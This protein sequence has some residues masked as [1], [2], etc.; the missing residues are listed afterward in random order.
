MASNFN[1]R[2]APTPAHA[3]VPAPDDPRDSTM[4][5]K[6]QMLYLWLSAIFVT[7]LLIAN[8]VGSKFFHFGTLRIGTF[9]LHIEHS[10][11]MLS[12]PLTFVLTDILNEFFGPKAARRVTYIGLAMSLFAFGLLGISVHVP[13]APEG[14]SFVPEDQFDRVLGASGVMI[15]ASMIAYTLG[16][17]CDIVSFQSFKRLT[18]G[19]HVWL[20]ATG[21]TV[22]SQ[23][24]DS[25]AI[26]MVLYTFQPAADGSRPP[27][28]FVIEGAVKGYLI[29]FVF[30]V[31]TTPAIYAMREFVKHAFGVR[32]LPVEKR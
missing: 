14:R 21:S 6:G 17:L 26:M 32:P 15:I 1:T 29:K 12:F 23:L 27:F 8:I 5:S 9:D 19:K 11:G 2:I 28:A 16:Q 30:A 18:G 31:L 22:V 13:A 25:F 24:V 3:P 7:C 4:L 10:V 20:R